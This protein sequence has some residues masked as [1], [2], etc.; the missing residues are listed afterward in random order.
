MRCWVCVEVVERLSIVLIL[1]GSCRPDIAV[2]G[3][4]LIE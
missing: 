2:T 3:S 4:G 1:A